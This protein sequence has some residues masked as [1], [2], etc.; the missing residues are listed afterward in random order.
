MDPLGGPL[1]AKGLM[2]LCPESFDD[3][4]HQDDL[5]RYAMPKEMGGYGGISPEAAEAIIG[6]ESD[7]VTPYGYGGLAPV[8]EGFPEDSTGMMMYFGANPWSE[9]NPNPATWYIPA[10]MRCEECDE[11]MSLAWGDDCPICHG[12]MAKVAGLPER[13]R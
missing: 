8:P 3:M 13:I 9:F 7:C 2:N 5:M 11:T 4:S 12:P 6:L 10:K 1:G